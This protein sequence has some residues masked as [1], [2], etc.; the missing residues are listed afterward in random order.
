MRWIWKAFQRDMQNM[1]AADEP[2]L[3]ELDALLREGEQS[4]GKLDA[5]KLTRLRVLAAI[6]SMTETDLERRAERVTRN[7]LVKLQ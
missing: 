1:A 6:L 3:G 5:A 7:L 2:M 4:E